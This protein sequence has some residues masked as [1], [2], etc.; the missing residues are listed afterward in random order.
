MRQETR[1]TL[2]ILAN[3]IA[4]A[5]VLVVN[6]MANAIP[7][8]GNTTQEISDSYTNLFTPAPLTFAIWGVIYLLLL[9]FTVYQLWILIARKQDT[10][11]FL[12]ALGLLFVASCAANIGFIYTWHNDLVVVAMLFTA[13]LFGLLLAMYLRLRIGEEGAPKREAVAVRLPV[14]VYFGW[15]CVALIGNIV[16]ALIAAGF[17]GF[18]LPDAV[19]VNALLVVAGALAMAILLTRYDAA[20]ALVFV[21]SFAGI[22]YE[23]AKPTTMDAPSVLVFAAALG[24]VVLATVV[25]LMILRTRA[26]DRAGDSA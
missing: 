2:L 3:C 22:V 1:R 13:A 23:R 8:G 19:W 7:I 24:G 11:E 17:G 10:A 14:S 16:V 5:A 4:V 12:D 26:N 9:L 18:G 20:F 21:W 15:S 6:L 25:I